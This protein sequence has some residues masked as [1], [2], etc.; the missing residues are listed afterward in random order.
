LRVKDSNVKKAN[1]IPDDAPP[2]P[3]NARFAGT[4][5]SRRPGART[6]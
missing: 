5:I 1:A 4:P 3:R 6:P 2:T